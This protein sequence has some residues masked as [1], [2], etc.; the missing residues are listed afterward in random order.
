M[1]LSYKWL[2]ITAI[3]SASS[4]GIL[5]KYILTKDIK[6]MVLTV[7]LFLSL[8]VSY[9]NVI[10]DNDIAIV[11]PMIKIITIM[12]V[13]WTGVYFFD[14]KLTTKDYIGLAIGGVAVY[15]LSM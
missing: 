1:T 2:I 3:L 8:I 15:L 11:Y 7:I 10:C 9:H 13:V 6:W 14:E 4:I 12:L 5:K